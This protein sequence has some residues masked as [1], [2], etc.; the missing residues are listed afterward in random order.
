MPF[1]FQPPFPLEAHHQITNN[2][3]FLWETT[4]R[5]VDALLSAAEPLK[6]L[7]F[8][9]HNV[10]VAIAGHRPVLALRQQIADRAK[11]ADDFEAFKAL[12]G[13]FSERFGGPCRD[14][15]MLK[16]GRVQMVVGILEH[17]QPKTILNIGC[18]DGTIDNVFLT[19]APKAQLTIADVANCESVIEHLR[20][21]HGHD[22]VRFHKTVE[23]LTDWPVETFDVVVCMEVIEHV[24]QQ[25]DFMEALARSLG[26]GSKLIMTT[27]SAEFWVERNSFR[28]SEGPLYHLVANTPETL[29]D[30]ARTF[31]LRP[32]HVSASVEQHIVAVFEV[33][34]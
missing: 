27:P 25:V 34:K 3:V 13:N 26:P 6:A 23:H 31:G 9:D 16:I 5:M 24:A 4:L 21:A 1:P 8:L 18:G 11:H 32:L 29:V 12:Y 22:R 15:N 10:P 7:D 17:L 19:V 20:L 28:T 2:Q 14:E 33:A 30:L